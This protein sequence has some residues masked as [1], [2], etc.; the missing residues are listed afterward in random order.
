MGRHRA[1]VAGRHNLA[2]GLMLSALAS[3]AMAIGSVSSAPEANATC[4]SA[5]GL[6]NGRGCETTNIGDF[7][8]AIGPGATARA[9][10]G[11]NTAMSFGRR[12]QSSATGGFGNFALAAGNPA[13][14]VVT[15]NPDQVTTAQAG[16]G[17]SPGFANG[18]F[19]GGNRNAAIALG[20]GSYAGAGGGNRQLARV[21]ANRSVAAAVNN[22][23]PHRVTTRTD[24]SISIA[25]N[26]S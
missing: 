12:A 10:G 22:G 19:A 7:A 1:V 25:A 20:N 8:I 3:G 14:S 11:F 2:G 5:W 15:G 24:D 16:T 23:S 18:D 6:G 17:K 4:V 26:N 13:P 9:S 21:F